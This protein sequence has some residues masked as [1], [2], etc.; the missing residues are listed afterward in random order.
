MRKIAFTGLVAAIM[1]LT[2]FSCEK[3]DKLNP[4]SDSSLTKEVT[5]ISSITNTCASYT[6]DLIAGQNTTVGTVTVEN[7][8]ETLFVTYTTIDD[9]MIKCNHLYVGSLENAPTTPTGNPRIGGF[10]INQSFDPLVNTIT[11]EIPLSSLDSCFIVAAQAEVLQVI[12]GNIVDSQT[13]W[14]AGT[15][16]VNIGNWATYF[17]YCPGICDGTVTGSSPETDN[18]CYEGAIAWADGDLYDT[19]SNCW[20]TY[21]TYSPGI[22]ATLIANQ[23]LNAGEVSFSAV[24]DGMIT[25]TINLAEGWVLPDTRYCVKIEGYDVAPT[26]KPVARDFSYKGNE[27]IVTF[28]AFDYYGV[29]LNLQHVVPCK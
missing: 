6:V 22:T 19:E 24:T 18:I 29:H 1:A 17:A 25:I 2:I 20:G 5:T 3:A 16:F 12:D 13:A 28:P 4:A 7:D 27:L 9:W 10:P 11:Y 8:A 26:T 15:R 21:V 14:G 23:T